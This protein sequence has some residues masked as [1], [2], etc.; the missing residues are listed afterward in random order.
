MKRILVL[1]AFIGLM[2]LSLSARSIP[3]KLDRFV[4]DV[5]LRCDRYTESDWEKA[6]D[7]YHSLI[8]KYYADRENFSDAEK[9]MAARAMGRFHALLIKNGINKGLSRLGDFTSTI[10]GYVQGFSDNVEG[11]ELGNA[12]KE[13]IDKIDIEKALNDFGKALD[14]LF[15]TTEP[16][17]M[18]PAD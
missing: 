11:F 7:E 15:R 5:E 13:F 18:Q 3:E 16:S 10:P 6:T 14:S 4:D 9:M 12:I 1:I 8:S 2:N 17:A